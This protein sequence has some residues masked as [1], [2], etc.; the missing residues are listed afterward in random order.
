[1]SL[2][3][4]LNKRFGN[5]KSLTVREFHVLTVI[6]TFSRY[7]PALDPLFSYRGEDVLRTLET[8]FTRIG[9]PRTIRVDMG[10]EV[11]S[12]DLD[13]RAY[14]RGVT[15]GFSRQGKPTDNAF[16]AAFKRRFR[17]ECLDARWFLNLAEAAKSW[18]IGKRTTTKA[19]LMV[20]LA[21]RCRWT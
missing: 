9:Y 11:I 19:D 3:T 20:R 5:P 6:D 18:R 14:Q 15:P 12:R 8:V 10:S 7:V 17:A 2:L 13:L 16:I 1:M 4:A 21:T